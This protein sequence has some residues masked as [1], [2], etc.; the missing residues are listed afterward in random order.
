MEKSKYTVGAFHFV[1]ALLACACLL[2]ACFLTAH[3]CHKPFLK[4]RSCDLVKRHQSQLK[5]PFQLKVQINQERTKYLDVAL[6][7]H[8]KIRMHRLYT[9]E[10]L[11][12]AIAETNQSQGVKIS[13]R[14]P[15][16]FPD[17]RSCTFQCVF[18]KF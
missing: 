14:Q 17:L 12:A 16:Q 3:N 9:C 6:V 15:F 7:R 4:K 11:R 1:L 10:A 2:V 8:L 13:S 18:S 5:I